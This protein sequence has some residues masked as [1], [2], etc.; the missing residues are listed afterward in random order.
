[1]DYWH[2]REINWLA[3]LPRAEAEAIRRASI[4]RTFHR[5][6]AVFGPSRHPEHVYLLEEGFVRIYRVSASGGEFTLAYVRPGEVFGDVPVITDQPRESYAKARSRARI[7]QIPRDVFMRAVRSSASALYEIT[8][9]I[10]RELIHCHS[11]A[12]DLVFRGVPSRLAHLLLR[13]AEEFGRRVGDRLAVGLPLTQDEVAT[14]IGTT[15]QTV[16]AALR[17]MINAGLL[18]REGREFVIL[19]PR[20]LRE[21][22]KVS[23]QEGPPPVRP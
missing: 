9:K 2:L 4:T 5:G 16:N 1:M 20:A 19:N 12:E 3:S 8:K 11:R 18:A 7:M 21:I 6:E 14:L 23:A 10:G 13:L 17:E 22:A 15:R